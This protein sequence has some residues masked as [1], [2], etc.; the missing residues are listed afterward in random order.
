MTR[1]LAI[2]VVGAMFVGACTVAP[3]P[4]PESREVQPSAVETGDLPRMV[5]L[6]AEYC[7]V[8]K[9]MEPLVERLT[10]QCDKKGVR[11]NVVDVSTEE[12][13]H[14]IEKHRVVGL[15]T[16]LFIDKDGNEV[17]RLVG[18]QTGDTLRQALGALRGEQCPGLG[19]LPGPRA[20]ESISCRS[21]STAASDV[22]SDS[23]S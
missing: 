4:E 14:L 18:A 8:C 11:V 5:A 1:R 15:P 19:P 22:K 13:E 3:A 7:P 9:R 23:R 16:Y 10:G 2:V 17:A 21:T 6:H 20:K 12:H